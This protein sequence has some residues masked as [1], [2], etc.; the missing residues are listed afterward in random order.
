ML[1]YLLL[2][3]K[4]TPLFDGEFSSSWTLVVVD[5][6]HGYSGAAGME[7]GMLLRRLKDRVVKSGPGSLRCIATSATLGGGRADFPLVAEFAKALFGEVFQWE[8]QDEV[9]QDIIGPSIQD[10]SYF[11]KP[12]GIPSP[13]LYNALQAHLGDI[14]TM[15]EISRKHGVPNDVVDQAVIESPDSFDAFLYRV[16]RG[17]LRVQ[18][19]KTFL[20]DRPTSLESAAT[21]EGVFGTEGAEFIHALVSLVNICAQAKPDGDSAPLISARYH[22][23]CRALEGAFVTFTT[24]C[25]APQ[26]HL[27]PV[28][29]IEE[30][31]VPCQAFEI[32]TCTRCGHTVLAGALESDLLRE[33][34]TIDSGPYLRPR[35]P[36][37]NERAVRKVFFSWDILP[38]TNV[39]EDEAALADAE[40]IALVA[41][42]GTLCAACGAFTRCI[43]E[44]ACNCAPER[45]LDVYEAT[46]REGR[47]VRCPACGAQTPY[48]DIVHRFYTGQDAP[49]AVLASSL[50]QH[51]SPVSK[52][53]RPGSSRKLLTFSDSRQDAAYFAPYLEN[54]HRSLLQRTLINR[55]LILHQKKFGSDPARPLGLA[56]TFLHELSRNLNIFPPP[57]DAARE[58][59]ERCSWIFQELLALDRRLGLEGTGLLAVSFTKP[60]SWRA[61][62]SLLQ[63]PWNLTEDETWHL[64][65][66]LLDTLRLS[67][68]LSVEPAGIKAVEF[69]PRNR[70]VYCREIGGDQA[71]GLTLLG[72]LPRRDLRAHV[73]NR[74][75][76][77]LCR[78]LAKRTGNPAGSDDTEVM[79]VLREIWRALTDT[80]ILKDAQPAEQRLGVVYHL[81]PE[82][83]EMR[84]GMSGGVTWRRCSS[85]NTVSSI[86]VNGIC[87]TM[88]CPG[89]MLPFDP[90]AELANHHYRR[91]YLNMNPVP[92]AVSEHTAQWGAKKAA[93]I[94]QKFMDG[95]I[96]VLS[97]STTFELGVDVGEL[98]AVLMR[99]VPP[100]T[101]NYVQRAGRAGR[102]MGAA[103]FALTYAQRR[104]HDLTHFGKPA[105]FISGKIKPPV[106]EIHNPKIVRRHLHSVALAEF[107]RQHPST[108]E[109]VETFFCQQTKGA[110][111]PVAL[112]RMLAAKP[113]HLLK[114]LISIVP[115]DIDIRN[116]L[117]LEEWGWVPN[118]IQVDNDGRY[119]GVLGEATLEVL[120]DLAA[121]KRLEEEAGSARNYQRAS[122]LKRQANNIRRREILGFFA[123]RNVL[124]KYGFPVDVVELRLKPASDVA[125]ELEL[126][127]DLRIAI[128]EYAPGGE[129]VA[130]HRVW[131]STGIRRLP[132]RDPLEFSYAVC[133]QCGRFHKSIQYEDLPSK[134]QACAETM[135][136]RGLR[137]GLLLVPEFGFFSNKDPEMV[138]RSRPQRLYSSRVFFSEHATAVNDGNFRSFP[139]SSPIY[140]Q[141]VLLY[142]FSRQGKLAVV[143]S[144]IANRGFLICQSCGYAEPAPLKPQRSKRNHQN[145]FDKSCSGS[146]VSRHLGHEFLSDVLELRFIAERH[147]DPEKSLWWSLLY[148]LLQGACEVLGIERDDV[149]GCLYPYGKRSLPP[150][151]VL[152]DNIPGGAGHVRRIGDNL[153]AVLKETHSLMAHCQACD[154]ETA[155]Y[156]CL[157][158]YDNQFCHHLLRRGPVARYLGE[159]AI[160]EL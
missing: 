141:T 95:D 16:L 140:K 21:A 34:G 24:R 81:N 98:Q 48:E 31:G 39:D 20:R 134:C 107:F 52:S 96:N 51:L 139:E 110:I 58:H 44:S 112:Q 151:I 4:D 91:L 154:E 143:N 114:S 10:E 160:A 120:T 108:F 115:P 116:E 61:L 45:R 147:H 89:A 124:P 15:A 117:R 157:K 74:R 118:L 144:G 35:H 14:Q 113:S 85:C 87:P 148:A 122:A 102:R 82:Y 60:T 62:G 133:R 57:G 30:E 111:A 46:L 105:E 13:A 92:M 142:R 5:E 2:R 9:R 65:E 23:F 47:L 104:P 97:C 156:A 101:A 123:S 63:S 121:Y 146:L 126:T 130:G 28:D 86:T 70:L 1:E 132:G 17:D 80:P 54:T 41:N 145:A 6:A 32:A 90:E 25:D 33:D 153:A 27:K 76:D 26:L 56:D 53:S 36:S 100:T 66:I 94:Q 11:R 75:F 77:Y 7:V 127:R 84:T 3:P 38:E 155:C 125:Q 29:R 12:W 159:S 137:S 59:K 50:Y 37:E 69:E 88:C 106:V 42:P 150:A 136:G 71:R 93:D 73:T 78:L 55:A 49:V 64:V 131:T 22:L 138:G 103:A 19:L 8:D 67:G 40:P 119:G 109:S 99:N 128:S 158:T 129:V 72:W 79:K 18:S 43:D 152:Y 135:R 68:C 83:V 149:N